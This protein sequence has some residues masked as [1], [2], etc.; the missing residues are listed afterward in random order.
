[1]VW[2]PCSIILLAEVTIPQ[3]SMTLQT[4]ESMLHCKEQHPQQRIIQITN[5]NDCKIGKC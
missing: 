4:W 3:A 5:V 2:V 1:M